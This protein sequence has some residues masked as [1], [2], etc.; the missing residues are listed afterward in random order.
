MSKY[1]VFFW[2]VFSHIWTE[3]GDLR[4]K[5]PYSAQIRENT[6][7]KNSVFGHFSSSIIYHLKI[8]PGDKK[9]VFV[10]VESR[11]ILYFSNTVSLIWFIRVEKLNITES[12]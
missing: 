7:Q 4:R 6:D 12:F 1:G 8:R 2:S 10:V 9:T 11:S 3:Y 5:S